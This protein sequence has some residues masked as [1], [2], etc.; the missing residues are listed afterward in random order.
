MEENSNFP[1]IT[2]QTRQVRHHNCVNTTQ[3]HPNSWPDVFTEPPQQAAA[4]LS[5][6]A[7]FRLGSLQTQCS[8]SPGCCCISTRAPASTATEAQHPAPCSAQEQNLVSRALECP[9]LQ[10]HCFSPAICSQEHFRKQNFGSRRPGEGLCANVW[11]LHSP[12]TLY[13]KNLLCEQTRILQ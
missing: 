9:E 6:P 7:L 11:I 3:K 8:P 12:W 2:A 13:G 1:E 4:L 5:V 10:N